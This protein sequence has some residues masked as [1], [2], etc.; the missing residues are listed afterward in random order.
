MTNLTFAEL[1][2]LIA[3][4]GL[5]VNDRYYITD[6]N[7]TIIAI[8]TNSYRIVVPIVTEV[9]KA[10]LDALVSTNALNQG[11]Q[12]RIVDTNIDWLLIAT[13]AN[14]L[15]AATGSLTIQN[16]ISFPAYIVSDFLFVDTGII[17]EMNQPASTFDIEAPLGY[18]PNTIEI[19]IISEG[20]LR[21]YTFND[22]IITYQDTDP[23]SFAVALSVPQLISGGIGGGKL[24]CPGFVNNTDSFRA[25]LGCYKSKLS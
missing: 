20:D 24:S 4:N 13:S 7:W 6:K 17:N 8:T 14:T 15:K 10:Q 12:Y 11:L 3:V 16:G 1:T 5:T 9:T 23:N 21:T 18:V 25:I 2:A 22:Q 19:S